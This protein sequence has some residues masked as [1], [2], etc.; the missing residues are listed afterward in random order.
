MMP[1]FGRYTQQGYGLNVYN[2]PLAYS[3]WFDSK[4]MGLVIDAPITLVDTEDA[5]SGSLNL[6]VGLNFQV[7]SSD[8]MTLVSHATG[9]CRCN[10]VT[11]FLVQQH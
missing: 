3:H 2:L 10:R 8:S 9:S 5:L 6:G 11:G 4:K 7:T 1:R